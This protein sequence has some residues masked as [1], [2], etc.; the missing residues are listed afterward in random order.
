VLRRRR[1]ALSSLDRRAQEKPRGPVRDK[2]QRKVHQT[3]SARE[4]ESASR[5]KVCE[6]KPK[7]TGAPT[8]GKQQ[9]HQLPAISGKGRA[10]KGKGKKP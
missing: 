5:N 7:T 2:S 9:S 10:A 4:N 6:P 8:D 3:E 1:I